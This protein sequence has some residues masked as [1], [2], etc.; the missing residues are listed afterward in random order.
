VNN[1]YLI[2]ERLYLRPLEPSDAATITPWFNNPTV[3]R[4]ILV[5]PPMSFRAEED[6]LTK[7]GQGDDVVLGIVLKDGD[8]LIG[9]TGL[10]QFDW[11]N[12]HAAFGILIGEVAQWN[13]GYGTEATALVV[14]HGFETLNLNRIWLEVYE[15]N[16]R[17]QCAYERVGFKVEG[18]LRQHTFREGRYWDVVFMGILREEWQAMSTSERGA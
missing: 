14:R 4:T 9:S 12:R 6:W 18:R 17:G 5:R 2:G 3:N 10:K 7:L 13:Q 16:P 1:P 8:R 15:Y 11:R